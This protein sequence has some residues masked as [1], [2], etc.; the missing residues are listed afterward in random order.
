MIVVRLI[1]FIWPAAALRRAIRLIER[2][3]F[4]AAVPL[5]TRA[6]N[7]GMPEAEY[8]IARCYLEGTGVPPSQSEAVCWLRHAASHGL[9][10]RRHSWQRFSCAEPPEGAVTQ[11]QIDFLLATASPTLTL[12][13]R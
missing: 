8:R 2:K 12:R 4:T 5:L 10:K 6:A 9:T 3:K 13:P 11:V 1:N 7:A